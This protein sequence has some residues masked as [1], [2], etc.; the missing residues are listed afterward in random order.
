MFSVVK[1]HK[2][3]PSLESKK[4]DGSDVYK[5]LEKDFY[6]KCYICGGKVE[7]REVEHFIPHNKEDWLQYGWKNLFL[8]CGY[9]NNRKSNSYNSNGKN[10]LDC[11]HD[12]IEKYIEYSIVPIKGCIPSFIKIINDD[13]VDNTIELLNKV[14]TPDG[15]LIRENKIKDS[16]YSTRQIYE[17]RSRCD[18]VIEEVLKFQDD[19]HQY[20][21]VKDNPSDP[22][23]NAY[24]RRLRKH[25]HRSSNFFQFKIGFLKTNPC[26]KSEIEKIIKENCVREVKHYLG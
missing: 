1:S 8:S 22:D 11:T 24:K 5:Q 7:N 23:H 9:C 4:Y 19:Y 12:L 25:F 6:G 16:V 20:L 21:E 15:A 2:Q 10:I 17:N 3:P 26:M 13:K 18:K 14:F